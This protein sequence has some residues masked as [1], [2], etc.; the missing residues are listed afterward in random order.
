MN[1]RPSIPERARIAWKVFRHGFPRA[2]NASKQATR[3][4]IMFPR[5]RLGEPQ[6]R[7]IDVQSYIDE[8]FNLNSLVYSAVMY[9]ARAI[10]SAPLRAYTGD[11][12]HPELLPSNHA[13]SRLATRPNPSQSWREYQAL[14]E[15]FLN[16]AGEA[17]GLTVRTRTDELPE[18]VIPLNPMRTYIVPGSGGTLKGYLYVPEGRS[19]RD[20]IPL[21]PQDVMHTKLPNPGD[22]LDGQGYGLSP[23]SPM[24]QSG[25]VD[26]MITKFIKIFFERGTMLT[27]LMQFGEDIALD[28]ADIAVYKERW[29]EMYGGFEN[30]DEV[31]IM[32]R[33]GDVKRLGMT[34][35]EMNFENLDE[36]NEARILGPFGVPLTLIPTRSGLQGATY[37]NK[38]EDR[39]MFWEDTMMAEIGLFEVEYQYYITSPD[40]FLAFDLSKVPALR[41]DIP[42][43]VEAWKGLVQFGVP[44][45]TASEVVG[46]DLGQLPDGGIA[47]MPINM[48]PV[49]SPVDDGGNGREGE[50][51]TEDERDEAALPVETEKKGWTPDQKAAHWKAVDNISVSWEDNFAD[52]AGRAFER[53]KRE[54]LA[55]LNDFKKATLR[56]K[57]T[58]AWQD[59]LLRVED[60]LTTAGEENWR[61]IFIPLFQGV[62]TDQGNRWANELGLQFDV[63]NLFARDWF[64]DYTLVFSQQIN[65]TTKNTIAA[66]TAQAQAEGW[67][68]PVMQ[69]RLEQVFAQFM[70]GDLT[71]EDFDWFADRMPAYRRE[72]IAR[73]ETTRSSNYGVHEIFKEWNVREQEWL[74]TLDDRVRDDHLAANGQVVGIDETFNVGGVAMRFPGDP[75]APIEQT[76]ACRCTTLPVIER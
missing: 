17:Y 13:L 68:I 69:D 19:V 11:F 64:N 51:A 48:I 54:V 61:N 71:S 70:D 29:K 21:L 65:E 33:G 32:D 57:Q 2:L 43:L 5:F 37:N 76:A 74:A 66:M 4:P 55:L 39:R 53:D 6:W 26:N 10:Q 20:G 27:Y 35:D 18:K 59:Y 42:K 28:D 12:D 58:V 24:A 3:M 41:Q 14:Q 40:G 50:T 34:F 8:G 25:D 75:N 31:G 45:N 22:P 15:V 1:R 63:E 23:F 47:Y 38:Q 16:I 72:L 46:L 36:R 62:I 73:T 44:K 9:K 52:G 30:W 67:S 49:S 60:Y 56:K 7:I